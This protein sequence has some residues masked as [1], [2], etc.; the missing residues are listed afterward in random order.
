MRILVSGGAGYIGS[1]VAAELLKAGHSV[2]VF[3]NLSHGHRRAV[4]SEAGLVVGDVC[5]R[6]A[7]DDVLSKHHFDAVMH[8]AALIEAGES[9]SSRERFFRN[10]SGGTQ[11]LLE[12]MLAHGVNKMVLSS[13]AAVYGEPPTTPI[14][15]T[16]LLRPVNPYGESK[17]MAERLLEQFGRTHGLRYAALRYFNAAG[18]AFGRGEDHHPETHLIPLVL[19]VVAGKAESIRI[20]GTDYPTPDGTC[21][22]DYVHVLDLATAHF[23]SLQALEREER[24]VYNLGNGRGFSVREVIH[25]AERVTGHRI[26][27]TEAARRP[28]DPAILVASPAAITSELGWRPRFS[29]MEEIIA[30]AWE[31]HKQFPDGFGPEEQEP[32]AQV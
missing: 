7:L 32:A 18:A 25:A 5:D 24:L 9:M 15:E 23:L 16:A 14:L 28:G 31:W 4:P 17:L 26:G 3:D 8:F 27:R 6:A 29:S 10:N 20:F 21:I 2:V 1:V 22:R 30:S 11:T 19:A 12:A 13:T